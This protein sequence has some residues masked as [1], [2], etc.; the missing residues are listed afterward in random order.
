MAQAEQMF[1]YSQGLRN[2]IRIEV[3]RSQPDNLS[4]ATVIADR[5]DNIYGSVDFN[6]NIERGPTPMEVGNMHFQNRPRAGSYRQNNAR[7]NI[8][9]KQINWREIQEYKKENKCFVCQKIGCNS[10]NHTI[11][12]NLQ[13]LHQ[14]LLKW[15]R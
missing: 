13:L 8:N 10:E 2:K 9:L 15:R 11:S 4:S 5:I 14:I 3:E 12:K 7:C 1:H 6:G